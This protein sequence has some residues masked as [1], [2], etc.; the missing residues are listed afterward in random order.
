M[1]AACTLFF[2]GGIPARKVL[3][4]KALRRFFG[5]LRYAGYAFLCMGVPA[6]LSAAC[7][8]RLRRSISQLND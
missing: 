3:P 4:R 8:T 2:A 7:A 6:G 1:Y 5:R